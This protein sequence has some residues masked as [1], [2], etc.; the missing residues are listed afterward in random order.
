MKTMSLEP[1]N[2][3]KKMIFDIILALL[4]IKLKPCKYVC[5]KIIHTE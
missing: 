2:I 5:K 4:P 3:R 1:S